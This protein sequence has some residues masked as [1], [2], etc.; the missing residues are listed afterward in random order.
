MLFLNLVL[1]HGMYASLE[2]M[3]PFK[4][5]SPK[6]VVCIAIFLGLWL[7]SYADAK[8]F[9]AFVKRDFEVDEEAYNFERTCY[10]YFLILMFF[11][12]ALAAWYGYHALTAN[13]SS[14]LNSWSRFRN[15]AGVLVLIMSSC[16]VSLVVFP[17]SSQVLQF[18]NENGVVN[19][20]M[21]VLCYMFSPNTEIDEEIVVDDDGN[22]SISHK[23][24]DGRQVKT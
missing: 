6:I 12:V 22:V 15:H 7:W 20:Y 18:V 21:L 23:D 14:H 9:E 8:E 2:T 3:T 5:Y 13:K 24:D 11:Y 17:F 1:S 16:N 19:I 10:T 4:F